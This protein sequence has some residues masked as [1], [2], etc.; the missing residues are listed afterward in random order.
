MMRAEK[1]EKI[2][3]SAGWSAGDE[4]QVRRF[5]AAFSHGRLDDAYA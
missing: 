3:R 1:R 5:A 4:K 2:L